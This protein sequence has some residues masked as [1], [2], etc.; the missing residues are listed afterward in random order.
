MRQTN[1]QKALPAPCFCVTC[2]Q[3]LTDAEGWEHR[4]LGHKVI[5]R[6]TTEQKQNRITEW[7][8]LAAKAE[9]TGQAGAVRIFTQRADALEKEV[10]GE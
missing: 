5:T 4:R 1:L 2:D 8:R 3:E 10:I 9:A 6:L 7:R